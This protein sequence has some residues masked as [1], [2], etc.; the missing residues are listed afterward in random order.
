MKS[1]KKFALV[2]TLAL[3]SVTTAHAAATEIAGFNTPMTQLNTFGGT[4]QWTFSDASLKL[5]DF[6]TSDFADAIYTFDSGTPAKTKSDAFIDIF[7]LNVP[8]NEYVSFG[9][10]NTRG[11]VAGVTFS[12]LD[13]FYAYD[14]T[15]PGV[16]D[17]T[18]ANR[19]FSV[20]TDT[21]ELD[22][23]TYEIDISGNYVTNGGS[24]DGDVFGAPVPEPENLALMLAGL[25]AIGVL[26][27]RRRTQA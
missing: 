11:S 26:A 19:T 25:G 24:F 9:F 23:G 22:S 10:G 8:D 20:S 21:F 6:A 27:R 18:Y 5:I 12:A 14:P 17:A 15:D 3:A 1:F 2:A 7:Y 4:N 13:I 16:Y